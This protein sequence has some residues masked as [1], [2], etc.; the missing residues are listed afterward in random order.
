MS[1]RKHQLRRAG[2][3]DF[4]VI[5][6]NADGDISWQRLTAELPM[7]H[8]IRFLQVQTGIISSE[9]YRIFRQSRRY[10]DIKIRPTGP[11]YGKSLWW[12]KPDEIEKVISLNNGSS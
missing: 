10:L 3:Y 8:H 11:L 7:T 5:K 9:K 2:N 4:L 12:N 6:F 1:P